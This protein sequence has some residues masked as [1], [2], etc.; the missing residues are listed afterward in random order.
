MKR[1]NVTRNALFTSI[2][3]LLL[4]VSMLV[5][6][7]FAW[8]T[9]EVTSGLNTIAAG[10]LDVELYYQVEGQSDW[11]KVTENSNI[12]KENALWEPG[13]T[14]V[15]KLKVVN[16]GTL[17]L[18]YQLSVQVAS[19]TGSVNVNGAAF[20][21]SDHIKFGVIDGAQTY[22]REQAVAAVNATA[23]ALSTAY[24][25]PTASLAA[26]TNNEAVVT[27]VVYMPT[28]VGNEANYAKGEAV[29]TINLGINLQATQLEAESDSFGS[30]YDADAIPVDIM[31][32]PETINT[33]LAE[34]EPGTTIGL[35]E[36]YYPEIKL[37]Q[38][39][40]TL[41]SAGNEATVGFLNLNAKDG[42]VIDSLTFDVTGAKQTYTFKTGNVQAATEYVAN[43]TGDTDSPKA[44]NDLVIRN[45]VFTNTS[46]V[47][48]AAADQYVPIF[49]HE[50]GA[51]T[52]RATDIT[53]TNCTFDCNAVQYI[54]LNYLAEG[55]VNVTNNTF[56][57]DAYGTSH[58][59]INATGNAANWTITGNTFYN[60]NALKTAIGSSKQG[61]NTVTWT[62][63][64]NEFVN[65]NEGAVILALK[66]SYNADNSVVTV[67]GNTAMGGKATIVTTDLNAENETVYG[68]HKISYNDAIAGANSNDTLKDALAGDEPTTVLL[69]SGTYTFPASSLTEGDTIICG[70]DVV[71]TGTSSLDV[72]GAT[73]VGATFDAGDKNTSASGTINGTFKGC[74]FTGGSEGLRWCYTKAGET[75]VFEDC[76]FET[77]FRGIHF[78]AMNGDVK[79]INCKINGFNAYGGTGTATFEK[80]TFGYDESS[81]N[82]LNIYANTK[83]IEC[84]FNYISGKTNFIDME[85]TGKT[86][87]ITD[88]TAT[89]DG[90]AA[91]VVDFVGGSKLAQNTLIVDGATQKEAATQ[92]AL[93]SAVSSGDNV[94]VTLAAGSYTMPEPSLQGKTLTISGTKE[95]VID[96]SAVDARDQFVTG[97]TIVFDGVTLNFGTANYMGFANTKSLTYKNC[98]I[99]GLQFLFGENVTFENCVFNANGAEHCV[100]TYGAQ[101]ISFTECSL[102]YGDR[103]V[104]VYLDN[105][106]G[107][108]AVNFTGCTFTTS[109][110]ASKGAVE[111]NSSA[112]PQG[113]KVSF[114]NCNAPAYGTM[115]GI[116]GW[117]S[118]NGANATITVD[119]AAF[120]ATQWA[121]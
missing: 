43:I 5:G 81:Y 67:A 63:S 48:V 90:A 110:T 19:E 7:T 76:I 37:T 107:S 51:A 4:C 1:K 112:F 82:G 77:D 10:N 100:W 47:A 44:A 102:T 31:A 91:D 96:V 35:S 94:D 62:V 116:S 30:D 38:D 93:D 26:K 3:S 118:A 75:T 33:I 15:V 49:F 70:D 45:C 59:T 54:A 58:N 68:G 9:D 121:K 56:G 88:C 72:D 115:V 111:I 2:I 14:E 105:G 55:Y 108:V 69:G 8:F 78:D 101:N 16:E 84:T 73:V 97:A 34:V 64:G 66:T 21:L 52:E 79:F 13:H 86:L 98:T 95:T 41:T 61:S 40:L 22:T 53:I 74:T 42:A 12:F 106:T 11:T 57:S 23:T 117:D 32:T 92:D 80:C 17:A 36:G 103:A 85:G 27:L 87:S 89:L 60:W 83:L 99:N 120:T 65:Y 113:A 50:Q 25:A 104:N 109:N 28:T 29:P 24:T 20:K 71:F 18:K 39:N 114:T 46:G 6:T 119:G